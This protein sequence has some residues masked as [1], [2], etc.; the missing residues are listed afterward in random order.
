MTDRIKSRV[1]E[2]L[3]FT[4]NGAKE[5]V[6][7]DPGGGANKTCDHYAPSGV[8]APP[9]P[10]DFA[11]LSEN[12]GKGTEA[13]TGYTDPTNT[14]VAVAGEHRV[15]A[16][17]ANGLVVGSTYHKRDGTIVASNAGGSLEITPAGVCRILCPQVEITDDAGQ[18]LARVGD[19]VSV[20]VP[21]MANSGGPVVLGGAGLSI[22]AAG[23][24][25]SGNNNIT[26]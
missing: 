15:Y 18:P 21:P 9:L 4:R 20:V 13:C 2:V 24:I 1:A 17:D 8:D 6:K 16:R 7:V 26:G 25:I 23:Q 12:S 22:P 19:L 3:A 11:L 5:T 14:R 10:G